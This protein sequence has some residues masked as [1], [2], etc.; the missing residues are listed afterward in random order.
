[1]IFESPSRSRIPAL[2]ALWKEAFGDT[3]VFLDGFFEYGFSP[4][5]CR[6]IVKEGAVLSAL[7]WFE[8]TVENQRFA[9]LYAVA[10]AK[11][12]RGQ[13][14]FS[15]L[16]Q[17][18]KQLLAAEGFDG[19]LLHPADEGL[20]RMY[21]KFGFSACASVDVR[22]I[23]ADMWEMPP[24]DEGGGF[25][26]GEDGGREKVCS[27]TTPPSACSADTSPD[28]RPAGLYRAQPP[29]GRLLARRKGRLGCGA[30]REVFAET[31]AALRRAYLP[32]GAVLQE[33]D[34]LPFLN[35]QYRFFGGGDFLAAGQI[36]EGKFYAQEFLG[37]ADCMAPLLCALGVE[38]GGF[39]TVGE[40]TPFV[41][42]LPLTERCAPPSYF[43]MV[44]D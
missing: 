5:R 4:D 3:D 26:E 21:E 15:A 37:N 10:T 6:C 35:S 28:T 13:G 33:G 16:L 22:R 27:I 7:Y 1:M 18:V 38:E 2:R 41:W 23:G 34:W 8:G 25:A 29:A 20:A 39:R 40:S 9:Y 24:S 44:L 17:D 31:Y 11:A 30:I 14:L 19:I 43:A 42:Y 36:Y 32:V 12:A